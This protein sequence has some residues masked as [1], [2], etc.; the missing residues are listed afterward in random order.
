[1]WAGN[2]QDEPRGSYSAIKQESA[3]KKQGEKKPFQSQGYSKGTK[4]TAS[5]GQN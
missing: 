2:I 5:N 3:P 4:W 1:M